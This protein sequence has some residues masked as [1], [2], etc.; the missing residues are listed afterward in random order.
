M[1]DDFPP[2][3]FDEE[4]IDQIVDETWRRLAPLE[5]YQQLEVLF[6][7]GRCSGINWSI[8]AALCCQAAYDKLMRGTHECPACGKQSRNST[9]GCDHCNL[10]DK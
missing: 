7:I 8:T 10:E 6:R 4:E 9:A 2:T 1:P 5:P 3:S